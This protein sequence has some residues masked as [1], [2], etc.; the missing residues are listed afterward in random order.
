MYDSIKE[1][2]TNYYGD[3]SN[4]KKYLKDLELMKFLNVELPIPSEVTKPI[5]ILEP[6][7]D[8]YL[9]RIFYY[10]SWW[11][12]TYT[13]LV[14]S[15]CEQ[16]RCY[17]G[18]DINNIVLAIYG[19]YGQ[20]GVYGYR[21]PAQ[22]MGYHQEDYAFKCEFEFINKT[23]L[24]QY[25][26]FDGLKINGMC[27]MKNF[28]SGNQ[29]Q[30][31][32]KETPLLSVQREYALELLIKSGRKRLAEIYVNDCWA[33]NLK[34]ILKYNPE[35]LKKPTTERVRLAVAL[36][37][38]KYK[39]GMLQFASIY[40]T[41]YGSDKIKQLLRYCQWDKFYKYFKTQRIM[42]VHT[43]LDNSSALFLSD[44][45]D[46]RQ[47]NQIYGLPDFPV[48]LYDAKE[49]IRLQQEKERVG[50][51]KISIKKRAAAL[52]TIAKD[53]YIIIPA[54][55][56]NE[57]IEEG[58]AMHHCVAQYIEKYAK[59][60][61][62]IYFMRTESEP[63]K[64]LVTIEIKNGELVQARTKDNG[65]AKEFLPFIQELVSQYRKGAF[66]NA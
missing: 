52:F 38:I 47:I 41:D 5:Q 50:K 65:S 59:G 49:K 12:D 39:Q 43:V 34:R 63:K 13:K 28:Y 58:K 24:F 16:Y 42:N 1:K 11:N 3:K 30:F 14:T 33:V 4:G 37:E 25:I 20:S 54:K 29:I 17:F 23:E 9:L 40:N 2:I 27:L 46:Y 60:K 6:F 56:P 64:S 18:K 7:N 53:G 51:Y 66:S 44:Y 15:I 19:Q 57:I 36:D 62:D 32:T 45:L 26:N 31:N 22:R 21:E 48:N 35:F 55:T 10:N 61:C 8:G